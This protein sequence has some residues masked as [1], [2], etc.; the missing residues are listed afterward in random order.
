VALPCKSK[1]NLGENDP[2]GRFVN[3]KACFY[4]AL[5][6]AFERDQVDGLTD[7]ETIGQ[8]AGIRW[9]LDSQGRIKIESKERA[10]ERGVLSPDRAEAL[11][12]ALCKPPRK[13]EYYSARDLPQIQSDSGERPN[14][15]DD[16][17]RR[18]LRSRRFDALVSGGLAGYFR[19]HPGAW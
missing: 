3:H 6:D 2:A 5:A 8:L 13:Y 18:P 16:L 1:P 9:E 14:H 17:D 4:Q 15:D 11:M 19:G 7:E 10:R 12:L